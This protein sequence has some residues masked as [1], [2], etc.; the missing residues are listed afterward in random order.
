MYVLPY[1]ATV[2]RATM[3]DDCWEGMR[4]EE[5]KRLSFRS[6]FPFIPL[7]PLTH[8]LGGNLFLPPIFLC[9]KIQDG[10]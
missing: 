10:S 5:R 2:Y 1:V 4:E 7:L 8:P 3:L 9:L 6:P